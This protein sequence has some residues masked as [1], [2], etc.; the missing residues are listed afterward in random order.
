MSNKMARRAIG[1]KSLAVLFLLCTLGDFIWGYV[2]GRTFS[3]AMG[4]VLFGLFSTL[5][6]LLIAWSS[7]NN[8]E[9]GDPP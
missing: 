8:D 2:E 6:V 1:G 5:V 9:P 3:A 4:R 7:R